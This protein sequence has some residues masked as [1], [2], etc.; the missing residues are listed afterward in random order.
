MDATMAPFITWYGRNEPPPD[1]LR[2]KAGPFD[3][4]Y[5]N[6]D[7]RYLRLGTQELIRRVYVAVRDFNWNTIPA[8]IS[9]FEIK[10]GANY[11][12]IKYDAFHEEKGLR[13]RWQ[14]AIDGHPNGEIK[15]SMDG[16]AESNFRY[17][18][19]GFCVLHPIQGIAGQPYRAETLGGPISGVLPDLV[20]PQR[21]ENGFEAP[22]FPSCSSLTVELENGLELTTEFAGD[23]FE[24]EDQ[25]NWTD[26]SF[27]TYCTPLSEGY[28]RSAREGRHFYQRVMM[29]IKG[30]KPLPVAAETGPTAVPTLALG[31]PSDRVFPS[32]GFGI[33]AGAATMERREYRLLQHIHPG[34]LKAEL[35]MGSA[36]WAEELARAREAAGQVDVP[37]ELALFLADPVE[38]GLQLLAQQLVGCAVERVI[39]F[40]EEEAGNHT[41]ASRWMELARKALV[42]ALPQARFY[43][44]TNGNFAELN[45]EPPDTTV[46]D[47]VSYTLN[48]QV[49]AFDERSLVE[50][51]QGQGNT[52]ATACSF[53]NGLPVAVSSV[54]LKP[55]FNPAATQTEGPVDPDRL[56]ANVDPR[57]MSLFAAAWTVGSLNALTAGGANSLTYY[58]TI[59]W[60]GL[61]EGT[62]GSRLPAKFHSRPEMVFPVYWPFAFVS[63]AIGAIQIPVSTEHPL[64]VGGL[65]LQKGERTWC[66]VCNYL[67]E[68]QDVAV[69]GLPD[70]PAR[71]LRLNEDTVG[72]A[73]TDPRAFLAQF[74]QFE[75]EDG[76]VSLELKPFE[77]VWIEIGEPE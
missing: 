77:T 21:M 45:R 36:T 28:P 13:Y 52:V 53:S 35:H 76:E 30:Q 27:K 17:N 24:M 26:G 58:E 56:P 69:T 3:V 16:M 1:I 60:R 63:D 70:G 19:I 62:G 66:L 39:V 42:D 4:E 61:I 65:A 55:P 25:R 75:V 72:L 68:D 11:F 37:L 23:L 32:L 43:G 41:T 8:E 54:T 51:L 40:H 50:A 67:P 14:A 38:E 71:Q 48:P 5:Q 57:Q 34:F 18:R 49:H 59:G 12:H 47:G 9:N 10:S 15:F 44:G 20:S 29:R 7:L 31:K 74:E 64:Q 2:L 73:T 46:M 6:G 33:P 22:L